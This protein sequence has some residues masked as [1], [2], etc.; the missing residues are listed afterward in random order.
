M[1]GLKLRSFIV[2]GLFVV[3]AILV[4]VSPRP[5][6]SRDKNEDWMK[7]H[8][9]VQVASFAF[10][11]S[12]EDPQASGRQPEIV[13]TELAPT[14]GILDRIYKE[15]TRSYDVVLIASSS[16]ASF[17]DPRVCFVSQGYDMYEQEGIE[18]PTKT[19]GP[20][21]A[22]L[23][24]MHHEGGDVNGIFFYRSPRGFYG[25]TMSLKIAMLWDQVLGRSEQ[26]GVFY[27][28]IPMGDP[29][30]KRLIEFVGKYMDESGKLSN[31]YF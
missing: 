22:T 21:P 28:F 19:R 27:R 23:V 17:H 24:K 30:P 2:A 31:G 6:I 7:A 4:F 13:Y 11:P 8:A 9:P 25:T 14:V 20:I 15:G 12:V 18:I 5:K 26:D 29:D 16:K 10:Q 1:E 3:V